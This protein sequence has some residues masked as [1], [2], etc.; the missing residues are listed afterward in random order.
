M[1]PKVY[2]GKTAWSVMV[3]WPLLRVGIVAG[4]EAT[5]TKR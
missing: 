3:G 5:T 1:L 2:P 4:S